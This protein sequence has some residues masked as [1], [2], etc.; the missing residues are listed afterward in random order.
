MVHNTGL[1]KDYT[2]WLTAI[3]VFQSHVK[4]FLYSIKVL[5]ISSSLY[6]LW[7]ARCYAA[8]K[9]WG[10][11]Q[12]NQCFCPR[13]LVI[14]VLFCFWQRLTQPLSNFIKRHPLL[15]PFLHCFREKHWLN[16]FLK[17]YLE[18]C[19]QMTTT[20]LVKCVQYLLVSPKTF[21]EKYLMLKMRNWN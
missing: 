17:I 3:A 15:R 8:V 16:A 7:K 12:R 1:R 2:S 5:K 19:D 4:C 10:Q 21:Y 11:T 9:S 14:S 20:L 6:I 18:T 13:S